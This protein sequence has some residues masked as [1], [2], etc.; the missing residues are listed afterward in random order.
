MNTLTR[1]RIVITAGVLSVAALFG[2][3][4]ASVTAAVAV[5]HTHVAA[6]PGPIYKP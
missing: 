5:H 6:I 3:G 1:A 2:A 4:A